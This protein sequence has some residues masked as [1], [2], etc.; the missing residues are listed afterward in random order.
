[1]QMQ[2]VHARCVV[3]LVSTIVTACATSPTGRSQLMLV[4]EDYAIAASKQAYVQMLTPLAREGKVDNDPQLKARV[5]HITGRLVA[6]AVRMRPDTAKWEW[7][8][9]VIDE[10]KVVNAWC[11]AGGRTHGG[12]YRPAAEGPAQRR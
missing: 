1:M 4:S 11:M 9:K 3:L 8:M 5:D 10:P 6:Q 2:K 12:V 7:S